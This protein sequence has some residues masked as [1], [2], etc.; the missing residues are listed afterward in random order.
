MSTD[1][2]TREGRVSFRGYN[3]WY[4]IVGDREASGKSPLL[5]LHGG[6]GATLS[7]EEFLAL[8]ELLNKMEL[9]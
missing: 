5:C 3:V 7:K 8:K 2:P 9:N 4:R 1:M 6:P